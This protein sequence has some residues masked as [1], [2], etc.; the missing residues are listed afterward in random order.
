MDCRAIY[1]CATIFRAIIY[2]FRIGNCESRIQR[3]QVNGYA[4]LLCHLIPSKARM[5]KQNELFFIMA[6]CAAKYQRGKGS[7]VAKVGYSAKSTP[8]PM[9]RLS[10]APASNKIV[11]CD[12]VYVVPVEWLSTI[13]WMTYDDIYQGYKL[14][15]R[16][17]QSNLSICICI[18]CWISC[19]NKIS[20]MDSFT[21]HIQ[22]PCV[23]YYS[24][25]ARHV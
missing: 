6:V 4:K 21:V 23:G 2:R 10:S 25:Q 16:P 20:P 8:C 15:P 1:C 3:Q 18:I 13:V 9:S 7:V 14:G 19:S 22:R 11:H 24:Q 17:H 12:F 5:R